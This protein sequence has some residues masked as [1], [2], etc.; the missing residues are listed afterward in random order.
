MKRSSFAAKLLA[1]VFEAWHRVVS[2][3]M[4]AACRF[5]PTCSCYAHEA[6][7]KHGSIKGSWLGLK[8]ISKCHPWGKDGYDPVP[9]VKNNQK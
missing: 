6:I 1:F 9:D 3:W 7:V 5:E 4:P 8:R 2:P